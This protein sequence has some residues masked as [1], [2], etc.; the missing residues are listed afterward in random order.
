VSAPDLGRYLAA[1][2]LAGTA[3]T[4]VPAAPT[5]GRSPAPH[6]VTIVPDGTT[7]A[8]APPT[9]H[10]GVGGSIRWTNPTAVGHSV[11]F[12][13]TF[14][15]LKADGTFN[16]LVGSSATVDRTF[17]TAGTYLYFCAVHPVMHGTVIVGG[18]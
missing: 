10:L 6:A 4:S 5:T 15:T 11:T 12:T 18:G 14:S 13:A 9:V 17:A 2:V 7:Y 16:E 1:A 3:C 8:F